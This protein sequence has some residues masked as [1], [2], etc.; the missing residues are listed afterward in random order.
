[1]VPEQNGDAFLLFIQGT[2]I[3]LYGGGLQI[4]KMWVAVCILKNSR[5]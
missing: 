5:L 2:S 4:S 3:Y 1:M